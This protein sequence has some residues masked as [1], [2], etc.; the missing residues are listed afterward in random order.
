MTDTWY[1]TET[2]HQCRKRVKSKCQEVLGANSNV[3]RSYRGKLVSGLFGLKV[4]LLD[5]FKVLRVI[6]YYYST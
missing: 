6:F 5:A 1:E 3:C 2:L 4:L